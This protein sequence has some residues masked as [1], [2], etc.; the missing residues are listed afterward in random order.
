MWQTLPPSW[1]RSTEVG[2]KNRH[3]HRLKLKQKVFYFYNYGLQCLQFKPRENWN[4]NIKKA[5]YSCAWQEKK[6]KK[7]QFS[8]DTALCLKHP[9]ALSF[10]EN[11]YSGQYMLIVKASGTMQKNYRERGGK[12]Y[13]YQFKLH[14]KSFQSAAGV[15]RL[16]TRQKWKWAKAAAFTQSSSSG[17]KLKKKKK[18]K[19]VCVKHFH[20]VA[21]KA[22]MPV[23]SANGHWRRESWEFFFS[24]TKIIKK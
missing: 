1:S 18:K 13:T 6:K 15:H 10:T 17:R 5:F 20:T 2:K 11:N 14:K 23:C 24:K 9:T 21:C 8:W 22:T 3:L 19:N 7:E 16:Q 12:N 4:I